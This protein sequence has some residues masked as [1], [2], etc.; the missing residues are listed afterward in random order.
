MKKYIDSGILEV[1]VMGAATDEEVNELMY[2]K[3]KH[4]E[5]DEA[6]KQLETDMKKLAGEM[7]IS[8]P[9]HMWEQIEDEIDGLIHQGN[10]AQPIKFRTSDGDDNK[11]KK[12]PPEDQFIP[13]ESESNHMRLHKSWR[14]I[15]VAVFVIGK[16]FL[17]FAIYF[18]LENRQTK[19]QLQELR[20]EIRELR[21]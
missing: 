19:Q 8:P 5:V 15:F 3:A 17:G 18:Y 12:K 21:K 2:M 11:H 20:T 7:A 16:I 4:P 14:W 1:F 6:L 9:Q 10:P 13:I